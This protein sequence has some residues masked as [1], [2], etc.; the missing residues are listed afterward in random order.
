MCN[1][2]PNKDSVNKSFVSFSL[3]CTCTLTFQ[4]SK[5]QYDIQAQCDDLFVQYEILT[6]LILSSHTFGKVDFWGSHTPLYEYMQNLTL[7]PK[8][9]LELHES[10]YLDLLIWK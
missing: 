9:H 10:H 5:G 4:N 8:M 6:T 1:F 7:I 2:E 3:L